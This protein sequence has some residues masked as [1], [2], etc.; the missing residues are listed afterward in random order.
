MAETVQAV[1]DKLRM[2]RR[3]TIMGKT[4]II[5]VTYEKGGVGKTTTAVNLSAVLAEKG[6]RVLLV[7]LDPQSYATSTMICTTIPSPASP[8]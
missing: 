4:K 2:K 5:A 3:K 1:T 6:F 7:D 8:A